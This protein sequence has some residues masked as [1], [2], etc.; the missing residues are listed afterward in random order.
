MW[1][2]KVLSFC[3]GCSLCVRSCHYIHNF[4][5]TFHINTDLYFVVLLSCR[6]FVCLFA[7]S[8]LRTFGGNRKSKKLLKSTSVGWAN[9]ICTRRCSAI[10]SSSSVMTNCVELTVPWLTCCDHGVRKTSVTTPACHC[11]ELITEKSA[12]FLW[13]FAWN[14]ALIL[15]T[16]D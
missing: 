12:S 16:L 4:Q 6:V 13:V 10:H 14:I 11:R 15:A 7:V 3:F 8:I 5:S 2:E 1:Q 9:R